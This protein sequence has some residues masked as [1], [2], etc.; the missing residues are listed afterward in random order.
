VTSEN[1][2]SCSVLRH[3]IF[4]FSEYG[5][6]G[7]GISSRRLILSEMRALA[8]PRHHAERDVRVSLEETQF[9]CLVCRYFVVPDMLGER[10]SLSL[11]HHPRDV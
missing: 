3:G 2:D 10:T 8:P 4:S 7:D 6:L 9:T 1:T 11:W 5:S